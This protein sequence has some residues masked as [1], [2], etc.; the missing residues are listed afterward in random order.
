[1]CYKIRRATRSIPSTWQFELHKNL[2]IHPYYFLLIGDYNKYDNNINWKNPSLQKLIKKLSKNYSVGIHLSM[3]SNK[4][5]Q[6][7]QKE[8]HRLETIT[9]KQITGSRQH[10]LMLKFPETYERLIAC[11]ITKDYSMGYSSQIGF[12]A[13]IASPFYFYNLKKEEKTL[14]K[15]FPFAVMDATLF[16]YLNYSADIAFEQTRSLMDKV[17]KTGGTFIFLAHN[18]LLNNDI[19]RSNWIENFETMVRYGNKLEL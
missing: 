10:F 17:K 13:G 11:G 4:K 19:S 2:S 7:V 14:L 12:R 6:F 1:M 3:A 18:D 5:K 9:G 15:I 8:I 16:Y